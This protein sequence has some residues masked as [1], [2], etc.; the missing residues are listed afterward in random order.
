[1]QITLGLPEPKEY[2]SMSRLKLVQAGVKRVHAHNRTEST[3][4]ETTYHLNNF[5]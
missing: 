3:K 2:A 1:M 4:S 5:A